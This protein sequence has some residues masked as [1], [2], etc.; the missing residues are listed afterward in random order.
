MV[1]GEHPPAGGGGRGSVSGGGGP[2]ARRPAEAMEIRKQEEVEFHDRLRDGQFEQRWSPAAEARVKGDPLWS[3]FKYYAIERHSLDLVKYWLVERCRESAVLD[4]CCGNGDDAL[5]VAKNGARSVVGIDLSAVSINNCRSRARSEG[6]DDR[7]EFRVMDAEALDF[8]DNSFDMV[9]EYG[10]LHHLEL[11]TAMGEL[12]RVLKPDGAMIC[13]ETLAHNP[14]IRMYR[15]LTPRLRTAWETEHII[16]R[17]S[18]EIIS[19][20]FGRIE[21]RFFHLATLAAVP[22]RS[23]W[24]FPVVVPVLRAVDRVLLALPGLRWQAWQIVFRLSEP[25]E[26]D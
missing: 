3:N 6:L 16:G 8:P 11:E 14:F 1:L 10:V 4:Y 21:M 26:P 15:R 9:M 19:R 23:T 22:L 24:L 12:A 17:R 2:G 5:F 18:F 20:H 25:K 13:T 7:V